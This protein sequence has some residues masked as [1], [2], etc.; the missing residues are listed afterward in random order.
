M[1]CMRY[2]ALLLLGVVVMACSV[3]AP[4]AKTSPVLSPTATQG[5][6]LTPTPQPEPTPSTSQSPEPAP[7]PAVASVKCSGGPGVAMTVVS[8][9]FIYDVSDPINPRLVCR[10][11]NTYV[12]LLDGNAIAYTTVAADHL[13]IVRRDLTTGAESR[14]A[15]LRAA[16][17][18]Y[19][20]SWTS[21]GS[22]EVYATYGAADVNLRVPVQVHVWSN[23]VDHVL[24]TTDGP[25]GGGVEGRWGALPIVKFSP[26]HAYVAIFDSAFA[27]YGSN[28][29]IFSIADRLQTFVN[30]TAA[31]G[32]TWV[33][34][35]RFAWATVSG[36]LM[37]WTP[38]EGAKLLR[39]EH[40]YGPTSS[41]DGLWLAGTLLTETYAEPTGYSTKPSIVIATAGGGQTF[42]TGLGSGPEFVT[43]TVVWYAEERLQPEMLPFSATWPN[44]TIHA[45]SV[46][47]GSD[48]IVNFRV[49][50]EPKVANGSTV[51]CTTRG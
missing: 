44:G 38:T 12:R 51:C 20:A 23:G 32:G 43:A 27:L 26:D 13:V 17:P 41:S 16:S 42:T 10:G 46:T 19:S 3:V 48:Q 31:S 24:Y 36:S 1:E 35:D 34:N 39:S 25:I 49:G 5:S 15:Q 6:E 21:D 8:G 29:R 37:Q 45:F 47:K 9:Q 50:E 30:G 11:A 7:T 4:T 22:L 2:T 14:S 40:W 18:P 33:A 28:V